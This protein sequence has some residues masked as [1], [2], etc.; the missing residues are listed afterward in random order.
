MS[1]NQIQISSNFISKSILSLSKVYVP[2][3]R[4]D[5]WG[6]NRDVVLSLMV[7]LEVYG[8]KF[9]RDLAYTLSHAKQDFLLDFGLNVTEGLEKNLFGGRVFNPMYP[10]FPDQVLNE[11]DMNLF[12]NAWVQEAYLFAGLSVLPKYEALRREMDKDIENLVPKVLDLADVQSYIGYV[13]RMIEA[14]V[15][16][17]LSHKEILSVFSVFLRAKQGDVDFFLTLKNQKIPNKE[18]LAFWGNY[19]LVKSGV[20]YESFNIVLK[21]KFLV[22]TD[23]L[24]LVAALAGNQESLSQKVLKPKTNGRYQVVEKFGDTSLAGKFVVPKLSRSLRKLVLSLLEQVIVLA[25]DKEQV[26]ENLYKYR[27]EWVRVSY[28]CHIGEYA[29]AFPNASAM[30][31]R[32]RSNEIARSFNSKVDRVF[33]T[34]DAVSLTNLLKGRPG[35]FARILAR[36]L[37]TEKSSYQTLKP[38]N[39]LK[40]KIKGLE[41]HLNYLERKNLKEAN[42]YG[43][44]L[45]RANESYADVFEE[46][47]EALKNRPLAQQ[48]LGLGIKSLKVLEAEI[49]AKA[50][51]DVDSM[52]RAKVAAF[53][54]IHGKANLTDT[55]SVVAEL[56]QL[57]K[58]LEDLKN[59]N[60]DELDVGFYFNKQDSM[61]IVDEFISVAPNVSTPVLLQLHSHFKNISIKMDRGSREIFT[62]GADLYVQNGKYA[63]YDLDVSAHLVNGV[64]RVLIERFS[65]LPALGNVYVS[66]DLALQNVP[67]AQRSAS[68]TLKTVSRGSRFPVNTQENILRMFLWWKNMNP[69][70]YT[71]IDLSVS[72]LDEDFK[73]TEVCAYYNMRSL[74]MVHSGDVRNAPNGASEFIDV[75]LR[76]IPEG[77]AYIS[78]NIYSYSG[79][80]YCDLP[81][82][83]A[84]W[85]GREDFAQKGEIFD[86][87]TVKEKVDLASEGQAVTPM[88]FDIKKRE[89][90]WV[91]TSFAKGSVCSNSFN[92][93]D[94]VQ[95][96]AK[97]WA[98]FIKPNLYDLFM[99][100]AKARGTIVENA[101]DAESIFSLYEGVTPFNFDVISSEY[102]ADKKA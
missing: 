92:N 42:K 18:N 29:S 90:I 52:N 61:F 83:F 59:K 26:Y 65:Q 14:N 66:P 39:R 56:A 17:S 84:G 51:N 68:K 96:I 44:N 7:N 28:A 3:D 5:S 60:S 20:D 8:Y 97:A 86:A 30:I 82:C 101:S 37:K 16:Y 45:R 2:L 35:V 99:L 100:H 49:L 57:R 23:V 46:N 27:S 102:M 64:E 94:S 22:T 19:M 79:E 71:D 81:E 10:N 25:K 6:E 80:R 95:S 58:S 9:S 98:N 63:T 48:L 32:V 69:S 15:A 24:R 93:V 12:L 33:G 85:M 55:S 21:D 36:V 54:N 62:K 78:V 50:K 76:N 11:S 88:I 1:I 70:S 89:M 91:D 34:A 47:M 40:Y 4:K 43:A 41:T 31:A 13:G 72:L 73:T 75:D 38:I 77:V 74:G 67:F 53:E 87:R